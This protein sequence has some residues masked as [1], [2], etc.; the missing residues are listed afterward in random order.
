MFNVKENGL[1]YKFHRFHG[2]QVGMDLRGGYTVTLCELFWST[3]GWIIADIALLLVFIPI[4]SIVVYSLFSAFVGLPL[5]LLGIE[6][7]LLISAAAY[8]G[9][10]LV[11]GIGVIICIIEYDNIQKYGEGDILTKMCP[12]WMENSFGKY[13]KDEIDYSKPYTPKQPSLIVSYYRAF[14]DKVCP[15]VKL[16]KG[17]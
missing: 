9:Y 7:P 3:L 4:A 1:L 11:A 10:I 16:E 13:F 12:D 8:I 14:K 17:K 6:V 15:L 5:L 2:S